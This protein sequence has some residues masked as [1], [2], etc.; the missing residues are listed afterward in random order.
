MRER[1]RRKSISREG[2]V[3]EKEGGNE[4]LTFNRDILDGKTKDNGPDH[5]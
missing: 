4:R 3:G 1:E 2:R 5:T